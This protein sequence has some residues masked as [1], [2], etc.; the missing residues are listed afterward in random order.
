MIFSFG[1][2]LE[3]ISRGL[4]LVPADMLSGSTGAGTA[5]DIVGMSH[6]TAAS[7]LA[8]SLRAGEIVEISSVQIGAFRYRLVVDP[9]Q[10]MQPAY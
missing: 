9:D 5:I 8:C 7:S 2:A 3:D 6:T 1:E 4:S 10:R